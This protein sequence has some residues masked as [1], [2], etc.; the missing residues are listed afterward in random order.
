[1]IPFPVKALQILLNEL[2]SGGEPSGLKQSD[3]VESRSD[4]GVSLLKILVFQLTDSITGGRLD[5]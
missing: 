1:M 3:L 4:D 5:R 2:R